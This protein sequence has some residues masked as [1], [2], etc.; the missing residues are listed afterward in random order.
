MDVNRDGSIARQEWH[1]SQSSFDQRDTNRDG[2]LSREEFGAS[3]SPSRT[4]LH[5]HAPSIS[6]EPPGPVTSEA[7]PTDVRR[8]KKIARVIDGISKASA[9]SNRLMRAITPGW[10][11]APSI[12][13]VTVKVSGWHI[14]RGLVAS[15]RS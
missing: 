4:P 3:S 9:S 8:A 7:S 12:R 10:D 13:P 1:W 2:R 14:A 15:L 11:R 6:S 5:R